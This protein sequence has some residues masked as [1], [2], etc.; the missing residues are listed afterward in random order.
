MAEET[1]TFIENLNGITS[2]V[3]SDHILNLFQEVEGKLPEDQPL[4]MKPIQTFLAMDRQQQTL[5]MVGRRLGFFSKLGDMQSAHRLKRAENACRELG[6]TPEN[7]DTVV[8]ELMKRY[9]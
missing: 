1:L 2:F 9:I 3:K 7:V 6:I 5:Y 4:M 8:E